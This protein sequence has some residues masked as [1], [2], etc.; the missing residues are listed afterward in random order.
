MSLLMP[1]VAFLQWK[2]GSKL[3]LLYAQLIFI[4]K[5]DQALMAHEEHLQETSRMIWQNRQWWSVSYV[6]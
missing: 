6:C 3:Q 4:H 5:T 2:R 1:A